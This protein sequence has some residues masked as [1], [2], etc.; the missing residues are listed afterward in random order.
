M[1]PHVE[2]LV[3][4]NL[5]ISDVKCPWG[6]RIILTPKPHQEEI[7]YIDDFIWR[8]CINYIR[9]NQT[10]RPMQYPIPRCD[11]AVMDE[12]GEA[13]YCVLMDAHSGYY[14]VRLAEISA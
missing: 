3:K 6:F 1:Q 12:F 13:L 2:E 11:D 5:I 14:Q 4:K 9:L 10:T 7:K 8:F